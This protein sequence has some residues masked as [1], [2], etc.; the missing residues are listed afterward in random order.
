[1]DPAARASRAAQ[2]ADALAG[3]PA[4][5]RAAVLAEGARW[6]AYV[7]PGAAGESGHLSQWRALWSDTYGRSTVED[8]AL[9]LAGWVSSYTGMPVPERE[10]R[11]WIDRTVDRILALEPRRVLEIGCGMGLLLLRVAPA[12]AEYLGVDFSAAALE[13]VR[14]AAAE[15]GLAQVELL[16]RPADDL[17]EV[18]EGRFDLV[19]LNSVAQYFP[20]LGY[21]RRV[22]AGAVAA[23]APGGRIFLGDLRSLPLLAAFHTSVQLQQADAATPLAELRDRVDSRL[24]QEGELVIDP[25]FFTALRASL[26][27]LAG[28]DIELRR[29]RA[30]NEMTR[31][32][33]DVTLHLDRPETAGG[34]PAR[35][36]DWGEAGSAP[37]TPAALRRLLAESAPPSLGVRGVPNARVAAD[38]R[39]AGLLRQGGEGLATAG[40]L[41]AAL[42]RERPPGIEPE[43]FWALGR[44]LPY[45]IEIR[46]TAGREDGAYDVVLRHQDHAGTATAAESPSPPEPAAPRPFTNSP[47]REQIEGRLAAELRRY[48]EERLPGGPI[49]ESFVVVDELPGGA[50]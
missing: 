49:P 6:V 35:W 4:V 3:H 41:L 44:D 26:P 27:R 19:I 15:R 36:L 7:V 20:G 10:M 39:A 30:R 12:C 8:P 13:H 37:V 48:L 24:A 50:S 1:M 34:E 11:E 28:V 33:Y 5:R 16:E 2:I 42:R 45:R 31:F 23:A 18:P 32:R 22:L 43:D 29:G 17:R 25:A 47:L 14:R 40:D 21:L 9:N 46:W 38:A